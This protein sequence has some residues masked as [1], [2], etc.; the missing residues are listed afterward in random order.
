MHRP[1]GSFSSLVVFIL[2]FFGHWAV[3]LTVGQ[4]WPPR[5]GQQARLAHTLCIAVG[6]VCDGAVGAAVCCEGA[7]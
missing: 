6:G 7:G 3:P 2:L 5:S 4:C 1:P